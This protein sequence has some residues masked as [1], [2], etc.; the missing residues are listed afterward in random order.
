PQLVTHDIND[1]TF[2]HA[3]AEGRR[4]LTT[5]WKSEGSIWILDLTNPLAGNSPRPATRKLPLELRDALPAVWTPGGSLL[6]TSSV[7]GISELWTTGLDGAASRMALEKGRATFW[8]V[9]S[10]DGRYIVFQRVFGGVNEIWR[11]NAD[12]SNP[13]RLTEGPIDI[14]P[15]VT[16]DGRWVYY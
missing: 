8:P 16:P 11:V 5:N 15:R 1:Y 3:D 14:H 12:G 6:Y 4:L 10:P 13:R 9:V 7:A 2:L